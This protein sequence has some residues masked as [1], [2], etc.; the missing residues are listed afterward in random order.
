M[1][2]I[3]PAALAALEAKLADPVWRLTS[4]ELY[5]IS[6]ADGSGIQRFRPRPEQ[7][8]IIRAIYEDGAKQILIPKARRLGM[9]TTL[10]IIAADALLFRRGWQ[11]SLID[12]NAADASRKLDRIVRVALENL[13]A[14]LKDRL[15]FVKSNDSQITIDIQ[16]T[17]ERSFYAGMNARGGS[18][19]FLWV[20]EWGVIQHEDPK[21]SAR[22]RSGALPSA[23]HGVTVVETTWA[24]G[25]GGDV[26][27]LLEPTLTGKANDW[28]VLF[29]PW[30]V[31]PRNVEGPEVSIDTEAEAYFAKI[32]QRLEREG[33]TLTDAQR[34][35]WAKERR[36]Q[37][38]WML[39][40]NPT[41]LDECWSAP[42]QGAVYAEAIER[43]RAEGRICAMPVDGSNLV[44]TSWDLGSPENT[45]VWYW[46]IVGREIRV[47]DCDRGD[48]GTLTERVAGMLAKGY[49]FGKHYLPHDCQQTE[50]TGTTLLGEL[51]KLL[52]SGSLVPVPRTHSVWVGINH[53]LELFPAISFRSPQCD[54]GLAALSC[55]R[56]RRQGEGALTTDEPVHDW[57]SHT[58]DGFRMMAEAHRAGLVAFKHTSA[59][60]APDWYA[61][62]RE[63]RRGLKPMRVS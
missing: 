6:P 39:R 44:H 52:P 20:S 47:I 60:P 61:P 51:A 36:S 12:Q 4:G 57:A 11:G 17:G 29:F 55:Y 9:S 48:K 26:W 58:A 59:A 2:G 50:R 45:V 28:R 42:I 31:D 24:G 33:I 63:R 43:A 62:G 38:I 22:I 41:F 16:A 15:K 56:T 8:A 23:R 49:K 25:K 54:D 18:N 14:W 32:A 53:A 10:G 5:S 3:D 7:V 34:R 37:G 40:E 13:P 1:R 21:R 27:E 35:W 30:W 46:Q 19:D